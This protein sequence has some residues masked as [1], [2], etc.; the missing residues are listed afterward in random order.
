M[1]LP[2]TSLLLTASLSLFSATATAATEPAPEPTDLLL[3]GLGD[4]DAATTATTTT[5]RPL[6]EINLRSRYLNIPNGIMD[7]WYFDK[8][9][10]GVNYPYE[11]PKIRLYSVGIEYVLKPRPSN[12]IFYYEYTGS[13]MGEGYW[14]DVEEPAEHDDGDWINPKN[15]GMH[16][17]GVN[18]ATEIP[19]TPVTNDVWLSLLFGG[20]LGIG[21]VTGE[22]EQW[23][24]GSNPDNTE[25]DCLPDAPSYE[26]KD[27]CAPDGEKRFPTV[28]PI[29]DLT[30]S[31][32]V[33]FADKANV[34]VD[35]GVHDMFYVGG[36]MG[37]VF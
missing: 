37:G 34:R 8:G 6:M 20:G 23:H 22:L 7:T 11:R 2:L 18:Y 29:V 4:P 32:R 17:L 12:W 25:L 9:D 36:A 14:D 5:T 3:Q 24:P 27:Q 33:N 1:P 19:V 30:G 28:L 16:S 13:L 35:F 10:E 21:F 26:R 31:A 15:F